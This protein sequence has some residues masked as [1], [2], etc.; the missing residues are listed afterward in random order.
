MPSRSKHASSRWRNSAH[1]KTR[2][3]N[4][5]WRN[6]MPKQSKCASDRCSSSQTLTGN[7]VKANMANAATASE[8][9]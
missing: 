3:T 2:C 1:S 5:K 6:S 9:A 7:R 8:S 4:S